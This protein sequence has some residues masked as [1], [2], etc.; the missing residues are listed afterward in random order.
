M[1]SIKKCCI[2][3]LFIT[4]GSIAA[5]LIAELILRFTPYATFIQDPGDFRYAYKVDADMG[6]DIQENFPPAKT[7]IETIPYEIFSNEIGCMDYPYKQESNPII[8]VGDSFTHAWAPFENKWGTVLD[9]LTGHRVLKCGVTGFGTKQEYLKAKKIIEKTG[10]S[11]RLLVVG[12]YVN[13]LQDDYLF[14]QK[15]VIKGYLFDQKSLVDSFTGEVKVNEIPDIPDQPA[16]MGPNS[17]FHYW[18]GKHS[19]I[20]S[21]FQRIV[22]FQ[23]RTVAFDI[24]FIP[25]DKALYLEKAWRAHLDNFRALKR[26]A[27]KNN[28]HLLVVL[29]P[30]KEQVYPFLWYTLGVPVD[31]DQPQRIINAFLDKEEIDSFDLLPL[32]RQYANNKPK[33]FLDSSKDLYWKSDGHWSIKGNHLAGALVAKHILEMYF[34]DD[35][36]KD[37]KISEINDQLKNWDK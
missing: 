6:Y 19:V 35:P 23:K 24:A 25:V 29:I 26:L 5:L 20:Y 1:S 13:D 2:N 17:S 36:D 34:P 3:F 11:P 31:K 16:K 4:C 27:Q 7:N 14:P 12:Y 32:F 37:R 30:T 33:R 21:M 15:T 8:L 10:I 22:F 18:L 28:S 9:R